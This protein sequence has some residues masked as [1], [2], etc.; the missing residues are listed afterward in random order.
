LRL[1]TPVLQNG[2]QQTLLADKDTFAF[3]RSQDVARN[4]ATAPSDERYLIVVNNDVSPRDITLPA[5]SNAVAGCSRYTPVLPNKAGAEVVAGKLT[6][7]LSGQD[8]GIFRA[9]P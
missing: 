9:Q 5:E 4:C 8:I 1:H 2:K 7:H 3:V 6:I